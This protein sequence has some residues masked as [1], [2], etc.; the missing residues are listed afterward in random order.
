MR[1]FV[2][3]SG[4]RIEPFGD[5]AR[6]LSVAGVSLRSWQHGLFRRF[7][8]DPVDV[9]S[10]GEVPSDEDRL[11]TYDNVFFTRRVLKDFLKR[12]RQGGKRSSQLALPV[13]S[14]FIES[15]SDLQDFKRTH[16][17]ALFNL[18]GLP[19]GSASES[20]EGQSSE[21]QPL[22]VIYKQKILDIPIPGHVVGF[23]SW[24]H[25]VTSS[26]CLHLTHWLHFLYANLLSIQ[27]RWVDEV[28]TR[29]LWSLSRLLFALMPGRGRPIWKIAAR[30]NR[31]GKNVSIHP[32]ACV[33]G[34]L[35]GDDVSIGAQATVR[36]SIVG[37]GVAIDQRADVTFSV[38]GDNCFVSKHSI[39]I[40][41]AAF[42]GSDLCMKG[43]QMCLVGR[44]AGLSARVNP[45][46][47]IP[48]GKIRVRVGAQLREI[49]LK[50]LG[51]CF[52]HE[53]W[54]GPDVYIAPGRAIPNGVRIGM[55]SDRVLVRIPD[56]LQP[57]ELYV[58][59][60][61]TLERS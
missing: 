37:R 43:M 25:P 32:T 48:G 4:A 41:T 27:I 54:I 5:L 58:V 22:E 36:G 51:T 21:A 10:I 9:A 24:K 14:A 2:I 1:I 12:W 44:D 60:N 16:E 40:A 33:E 61:G 47:T 17:H 18:W 49:D 11:V 23:E 46:D 57:G 15:F 59:Q 20:T 26:V 6:D 52:G 3:D 56:D 45:M 42:E 39:I 7:G 8:L 34:C 31:L 35:I 19:A 13:D 53:T 55:R 50:V 30:A 29:P 38:L 28:L